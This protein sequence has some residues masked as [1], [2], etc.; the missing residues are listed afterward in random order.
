[1]NWPEENRVVQGNI[2]E[3]K[4]PGNSL[5]SSKEILS[6]EKRHCRISHPKVGYKTISQY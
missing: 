1:M 3:P 6:R 4:W 5:L 2:D